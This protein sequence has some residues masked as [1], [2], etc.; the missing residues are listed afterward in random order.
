M[1]NDTVGCATC[2]EVLGIKAAQYHTPH[3]DRVIPKPYCDERCVKWRFIP[4]HALSD[5]HGRVL[6]AEYVKRY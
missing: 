1:V 6:R 2:G 3:P 4:T 5:Y